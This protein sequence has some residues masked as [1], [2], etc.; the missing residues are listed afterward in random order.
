MNKIKEF[1][2]QLRLTQKDLA[3][4]MN[5]TQQTIGRWENGTSEP[6]LSNLRDLAYTLGTTTSALLGEPLASRQSSH[7]HLIFKQEPD[8]LD[9]F[10]GNIGVLPAHHTASIWYPITLGS[11]NDASEK[12]EDGMPFMF[13]SLNNKLV[14]INPKHIK[15]FVTLDDAADPFPNDW[16]ISWHESG[17]ESPEI[18]D[19][20]EIYMQETYWGLGEDPDNSLSDSL[21]AVVKKMVEEY[22]LDEDAILQLTNGIRIFYADGSMESYILSD[23]SSAL[24]LYAELDLKLIPT[25]VVIDDGNFTISLP[26]EAISVIE[27]PLAKVTGNTD[28]GADMIPG[29]M[30]EDKE[31]EEELSGDD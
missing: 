6:S 12:I 9:G 15:R 14:F 30:H 18:F 28:K 27:F 10:W 22:K 3:T 17:Y 21:R 1:R 23:F 25:T 5:T 31:E 19:A 24:A 29:R 26:L 2:S 11:V 8:G 4:L 16:E 20:L 13:E 7:Y